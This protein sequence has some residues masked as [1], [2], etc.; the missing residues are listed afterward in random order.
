VAELSTADREKIRK[1]LAN[2]YSTLWVETDMSKDEWQAAI[3]A[4]DTWIDAN[5]G[6]YNSAL[7]ATAQASLTAAQKTLMFCA[8][9]A[10]RVS[11]A[12]AV[13]LLGN[14]D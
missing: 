4:T 11:Q 9:A 13:R 3:N 7:P 6:S 8:V 12:F 2:Y 10:F 1:G 5:A 14:L